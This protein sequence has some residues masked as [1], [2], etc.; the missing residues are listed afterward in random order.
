MDYDYLIVGCGLSGSVLAER[1]A[2][3]L[4]KTVLIIDRRGH[5]GGNC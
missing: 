3:V 4:D 2:T 1:I 5:I